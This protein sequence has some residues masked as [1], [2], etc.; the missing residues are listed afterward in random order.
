MEITGI[1]RKPL[2]VF[3]IANNHQGCLEH[4]LKIIREIGEV[5]KNYD[6]NFAFKLQYRDLETFI[7]DDFKERK[8][9]KFVKRFSET[10]L[11]KDQYGI[12]KNEI[13][14]RGFLSVCTPFDEKS[15][16]L[17]E[18]QNFDVI[19]IA[20]CS[21]TDWPLLERIALTDKPVIASTAGVPLEDIDKVVSFFRH[22][23]KNM[24]L[25]SCVAEYPAK[26]EN[27]QLNQ[28]DLLK[29][30]YPQIN[31][32]YSTHESP[33]NFDS[34]KIAIAKG[35]CIFEK[36]V[37]AATGDMALNSYSATPEQIAHWL[38]SAKEAFEMCGVAEQRCSFTDKEESD[39]RDLK[40]G[41]FA[42]I[43][44][45]K[46]DVINMSNVFFAIPNMNNQMLANDMSKYKEIYSNIHIDANK[47]IFEQDIYVVDIR[48]KVAAY[49]S[50]V[51]N[52]LLEARIAIPCKAEFELSHHYG[53]E[54]F[55]Q[56][57][58]TI[59]N[60]INREY[61]KK[62][63]VL[64]PGQRH[65]MHYHKLKEETFY[66]LSGKARINLKGT[67][68]EYGPGETVLVE[69]GAKHGFNADNGVVFEEISTTHFINDSYYDDEKITEN[70]KRKVELTYWPED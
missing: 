27:L 66:V 9:I 20:S 32:G 1:N 28:I 7:H 64:L 34:I 48:E 68:K 38:K 19:K 49:I 22:R 47:P 2:F 13:T 51:K 14:Q 59:I 67:E 26:M 42:K 58:A 53:I 63:I 18:E 65:P 57:G 69:R 35:A 12:L 23:R 41:V 46:G 54:N 16:N 21:F 33:E 52:I 4:G 29:K 62:L 31:I 5:C 36:H 50:D 56:F 25:M 10:R 15:V 37:G 45:S 17:I 11:T 6:F 55:R 70:R 3:E 24:A 44:I 39:L 61:C 43:P 60:C 40:R 8:D 30:R